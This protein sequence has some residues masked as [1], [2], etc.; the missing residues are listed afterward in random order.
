MCPGFTPPPIPWVGPD[1]AN[2]PRKETAHGRQTR[3]Q[4]HSDAGDVCQ[5]AGATYLG[6]ALLVGVSCLPVACPREVGDPAPVV[7]AG[8]PAS[9]ATFSF[10]GVVREV[11][12]L[13]PVKGETSTANAKRSVKRISGNRTRDHRLRVSINSLA[14]PCLPSYTIGRKAR[15]VGSETGHGARVGFRAGAA[16]VV[17][18]RSPLAGQQFRQGDQ[19]EAPF[20]QA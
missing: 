20:L 7:P 3:S 13:Q 8:V 19:L 9:P 11:L 10:G 15:K 14:P 5:L 12:R 16:V 18:R 4:Y 17:L 1:G 6:I 2:A